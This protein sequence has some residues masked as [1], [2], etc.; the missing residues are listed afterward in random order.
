ME[1]QIAPRSG[2]TELLD[3]DWSSPLAR[4]NDPRLVRMA[5]AASRHVVRFVE[6]GGHVFAVKEIEDRFAL[7]EY[8]TLRAMADSELPA[9]EAVCT[10]T[11]RRARSGEPLAG[12]LVTRYLDFALPY[13]YLLARE[14]SA[15]HQRRLID[16]AAVLVV[17]LHLEGFF[18]GDCSLANVLFRRDAGALAAYLVDAETA[19]R[20]ERLTDGQRA[21]DIELAV[22]NVAGGVADLVAAGR[23]PAQADPMLFAE[24]LEQR[25][26]ALWGE[27]TGEEEYA[28]GERWRVEERIGRLNALGFDA[29]ELALRED[30]SGSRL[31]IRPSVVEEGHHARR[32]L[33]LTGIDAQE[34]QARRLLNDLDG[35]RARLPRVRGR[36]ASEAVAAHRWL[37]E[38]FEPFAES[39]PAELRGR[40]EPVE[41]YHQYLEHRWY[42]SEAARRDIDGNAARRSYL[43]TVLRRRPDEIVVLPDPTGELDIAS[44]DAAEEADED[45]LP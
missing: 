30:P 15:E 4:W 29:S 44:L 37:T 2:D 12:A 17:Q 6:V 38:C 18:W 16:A 40:L 31:R 27:L 35:Y 3:L 32:L 11:D 9:V 1:V 13:T 22:A 41:A 20:H 45:P 23:L 14:N 5:R 10:V 19:E 8:N 36:P 26:E 21:T 28:A 7:R 42:L 43:E 34:N 33:R 24:R 25:Y 39:I